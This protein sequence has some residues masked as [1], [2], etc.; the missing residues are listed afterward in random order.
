[1]H[2]GVVAVAFALALLG[3]W[4]SWQYARVWASNDTLMADLVERHPESFHAPWW[5]G[6]RLVDAGE[7]DRGVEWLARAVALNPNEVMVRLDYARALLLAGRSADAEE[8]LRPIPIGLHPSVSV[9]LAQSFI[10]RDRPAEALR[11]VEEG[12]RRFPDDPRL[13]EQRRQLGA[14][15]G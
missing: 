6:R 13:R 11:A 12:L 10:F 15:G 14:G 1:M 7:I 5:T 8:Q 9:F 3:G 4:R 2:R